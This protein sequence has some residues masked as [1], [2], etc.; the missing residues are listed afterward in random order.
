MTSQ[1]KK[2]IIVV[3]VILLAIFIYWKYYSKE[4]VPVSK[5]TTNVEGFVTTGSL[6]HLGAIIPDGIIGE[7]E[8]VN[9]PGQNPPSVDN[10]LRA[11]DF[12]SLVDSGDQMVQAANSESA[13]RPLERL[14]NLSDSYFPTIASKALPFSQAA[15]KPLYHHHAVN[16]PR[17][18][19]KG[20][21]YE[22][23]LSEAVR[24]T[25]AIN[26][27]PNVSLIASSEYRNEDVFNPGFMTGA[28]D[29][30]YN[31][32]TG[33]HKNLPMYIGGSGD[34][35]YGNVGGMGIEAIYDA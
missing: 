28:Y 4:E 24:G 9:Q 32:L 21:L 19:L 6:Q 8:L 20:K 17:V 7:Y 34:A 3:V 33:S 11:V 1:T 26:Y 14:Q 18:N 5:A 22:M 25:V 16:L 15:A 10:S 29:S 30:L 13:Q 23:N 31:K 2:I 12:A 27:D 35:S